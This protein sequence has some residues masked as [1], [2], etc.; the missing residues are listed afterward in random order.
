[1][2]RTLGS[3]GGGGEDSHIKDT[4]V[5]IGNILKKIPRYQLKVP[6]SRIMGVAQNVFYHHEVLTVTHTHYLLS[7]IFYSAQC[8][9][10]Y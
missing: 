4:G 8:T 3:W 5:P 9:K 1:M 10:R 6:R 7:V 2:V